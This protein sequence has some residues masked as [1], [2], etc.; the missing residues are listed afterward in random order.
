MELAQP[1]QA[2]FHGGAAGAPRQPLQHHPPIGDLASHQRPGQRQP[3]LL[4]QLRLPPGPM[5]IAS[6][7]RL[8]AVQ[9]LS[10][11]AEIGNRNAAPETGADQLGGE[12][13]LPYHQDLIQKR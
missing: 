12:L 6:L 11:A 1:P 13:H 8:K 2:R 3:P 9:A 7:Q 10:S 5:A 4:R